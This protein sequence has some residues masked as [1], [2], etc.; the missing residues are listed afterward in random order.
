MR[1]C[2]GERNSRNYYISC[3][4][5]SEWFFCLLFMSPNKFGKPAIV[6]NSWLRVKS[7]TY[8]I[9]NCWVS[10]VIYWCY[11]L[12]DLAHRL[13]ASVLDYKGIRINILQIP[14]ICWFVKHKKFEWMEQWLYQLLELKML[15]SVLKH[16]TALNICALTLWMENVWNSLTWDSR[17]FCLSQTY[18]H[19]YGAFDMVTRN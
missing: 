4:Y 16:I 7:G 15:S 3:F 1:V 12:V 8:N 10:F 19:Q 9:F 18:T 2:L 6:K 14:E 17:W 5:F 11:W 13:I